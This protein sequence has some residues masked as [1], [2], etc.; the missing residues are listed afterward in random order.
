MRKIL[1]VNNTN[2]NDI[3]TFKQ[4]LWISKNPIS[5]CWT[6]RFISNTISTYLNS[7][8]VRHQKTSKILRALTS[9]KATLGC[10]RKS[11][12]S[13]IE[14]Y[15]WPWRMVFASWI[16]RATITRARHKKNDNII[17]IKLIM[18]IP[19]N[20]KSYNDSCVS[21]NSNNNQKKITS[22]EW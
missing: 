9:F 18:N 5:T 3:T 6:K 8:K 7:I 15:I 17:M 14:L 16:A 1:V 2:I 21:N 13:E 20:I 22:W 12:K 11:I 19:Y 10:L 4:A